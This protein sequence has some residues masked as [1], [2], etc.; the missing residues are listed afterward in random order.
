MPALPQFANHN[1]IDKLIQSCPIKR[2]AFIIQPMSQIPTMLNRLEARL[3]KLIEGSMGRLFPAHDLRQTLLQHLASA[4]QSE[5]RLDNSLPPG[6]ESLV[7]PDQFTIFLPPDEAAGLKNQASL[8]TDLA[9]ELQQAAQAEHVRFL[10]PPS[11]RVL[12]NP[13]QEGGKIQVLAQFSLVDATRT[14]TLQQIP[15]DPHPAIEVPAAFLIVDGVRTFHIEEAL[16]TIG[17]QEGN[18]L[19]IDDPRVSRRHAQL[20]FTQNRFI[21]FDLGSTGGTFVNDQPVTQHVLV[22]GDVIS[23]G[24]IPL[25]FGIEPGRQI[26]HTQTIHPQQG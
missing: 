17:R 20:R 24:G 7:A 5:L 1:K 10:N 19:I 16:T 12:P 9:H 11:I 21:L 26:S 14:A 8:L 13:E 23:L 25:I 18:T 22:S 15:A 2:T 4:M 3:Q 6:E